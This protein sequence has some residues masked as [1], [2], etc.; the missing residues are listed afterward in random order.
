MRC[1]FSVGS[2]L[3]FLYCLF[4]SPVLRIFPCLVGFSVC[5]G[6]LSA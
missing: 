3:C 4:S 5:K 2:R 1:L 6:L